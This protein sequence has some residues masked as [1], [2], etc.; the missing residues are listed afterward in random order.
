MLVAIQIVEWIPQVMP[1]VI[2]PCFAGRYVHWQPS[3][4]GMAV[5]L[6]H[7]VVWECLRCLGV[8]LADMGA[9]AQRA[10]QWLQQAKRALAAT[11]QVSVKTLG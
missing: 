6:K 10:S 5:C 4:I 8:Q 9:G 3:C 11:S 1:S 7:D 2:Q